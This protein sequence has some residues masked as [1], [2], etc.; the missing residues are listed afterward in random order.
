MC[1]MCE[2]VHLNCTLYAVVAWKYTSWRCGICHYS[3]ISVCFNTGQQP[4]AASCVWEAVWKKS[5]VWY[6]WQ[7]KHCT[8]LC[9]SKQLRRGGGNISLLTDAV[10][11]WPT[12]SSLRL[13]THFRLWLALEGGNGCQ[14]AEEITLNMNLS[15][16]MIE[17]L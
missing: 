7:G 11:S 14:E 1:E 17:I 8:S 13:Q 3:S 16:Y 12:I 15:S 6:F 4:R 9:M 5:L 2:F 10:I